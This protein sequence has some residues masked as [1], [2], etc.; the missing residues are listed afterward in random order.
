MTAGRP[1][2]SARGVSKKYRIRPERSLALG[3]VKRNRPRDHWALSELDLDVAPGEVLAVVGRNGAGKSTLLKISAGVTTPTTGTLRRP[4]RVAPLIEVGAGFHPD[5]TGREN[6]VVNARL[7]GVGAR[8]IGAVFESVVDFAELAHAIDQPVRQYSSGMFMR[9]GFSV[10]VHTRPELLIVD[11]VLAV[12]DMPFQVRCLERIRELRS[13]GVGVLFVSHN[14]SAVLSLADRAIFLEQGQL[15][16][17][18]QTK[19]VVGAYHA[20]LAEE[21]ADRDGS[22]GSQRPQTTSDLELV[23][24][25]V[26]DAGGDQPALWPPGE[27]AVVH[28]RIRALA[29]TPQA[30]VGVSVTKEGAG[31][32][33]KYLAEDGPFIP[34]LAAGAEWEIEMRLRLAFTEGGY[35]F[36]MAVGDPQTR[37]Q[38]LPLSLLHRFGLSSRVGASGLVD[39]DPEISLRPRE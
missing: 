9:L 6:I 2:L 10:A 27:Q 28:V 13:N 18:G 35:L 5:L 23:D 34:P 24:V 1:L 21:V 25:T 29:D 38:L 4:E 12:G 37:R 36:E 3:F 20:S 16:A 15:R 19:D 30:A 7:L 39:L 8:E 17:E 11:E 14:L 22:H 33:A 32:V 26:T 31:L